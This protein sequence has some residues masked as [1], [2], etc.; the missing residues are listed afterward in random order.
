MRALVLSD[1]LLLMDHA[2]G[3]VVATNVAAVM[4]HHRGGRGGRRRR[5]GHVAR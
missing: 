5:D 2:M 4:H 1:G 3:R